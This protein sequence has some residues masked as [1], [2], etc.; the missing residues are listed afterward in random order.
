MSKPI[1]YQQC[2]EFIGM[3]IIEA[4][5]EFTTVGADPLQRMWSA[6]GKIPEIALVDVRNIW[7]AGGIENGHAA[8]AVRHDRPLGSLMP[9]QLPDSACGQPHIDA[10]YLLRNRE[11]FHRYLAGPAAVLDALWRIVE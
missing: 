3:A 11:V 10:G 9:V 5:D 7:L 2:V 8:T 6:G 1:R 4:N